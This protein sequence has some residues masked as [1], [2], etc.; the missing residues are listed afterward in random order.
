MLL[1]NI[2]SLG[3]E[4]ESAVVLI[5]AE[6]LR[7]RPYPDVLIEMLTVLLIGLKNR[8]VSDSWCRPHPRISRIRGA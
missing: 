4:T 1:R 7:N 8:L 5:D 2:E 3:T 6:T